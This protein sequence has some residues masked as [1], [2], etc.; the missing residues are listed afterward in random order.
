MNY[1]LKQEDIEE[2]YDLI[3]S[4]PAGLFL[5]GYAREAGLS[6]NQV[7]MLSLLSG[8]AGGLLLFYQLNLPV[9]SVA[10]LLIILSGFLD[11]A[12]GQLARM[13]NTTSKTGMIIDGVIDNLVFVACYLGGSLFFFCAVWLLYFYLC[14]LSRFAA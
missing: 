3:L 8:A 1:Y 10:C 4:R 13:T 6:P 9:L 2:K 11:S 5:A 14:R 7:S 12:D